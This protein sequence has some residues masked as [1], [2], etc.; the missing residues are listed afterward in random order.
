MANIMHET[1]LYPY[2]LHVKN[3]KKIRYLNLIDYQDNL[4]S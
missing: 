4:S 1:L 2:Q 3:F